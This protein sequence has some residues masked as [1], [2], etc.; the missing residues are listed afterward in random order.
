MDRVA[1]P[2]AS[3]NAVIRAECARQPARTQM[4]SAV[5]DK[6]E[7]VAA[8]A[9]DVGRVE[10]RLTLVDRDLEALGLSIDGILKTG[11][12]RADPSSA[13][14]QVLPQHRSVR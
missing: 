9:C 7:Q 2:V 5:R 10:D 6:I 14:L 13:S 1:E 4:I 3:V 8:A 11:F 12:G